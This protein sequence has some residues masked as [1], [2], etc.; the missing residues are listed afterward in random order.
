MLQLDREQM[1]FICIFDMIFDL[2]N[3]SLYN[4]LTVLGRG[5]KQGEVITETHKNK[6]HT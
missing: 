1:G 3:G 2:E 6:E 4:R 5:A